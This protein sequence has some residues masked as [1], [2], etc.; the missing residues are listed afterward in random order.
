MTANDQITHVMMPLNS[1]SAT[2]GGIG[3]GNSSVRSFV[4]RIERVADVSRPWWAKN[5]LVS[6]IHSPWPY[7]VLWLSF[8]FSTWAWRKRLLSEPESNRRRVSIALL[9]LPTKISHWDLGIL[10]IVAGI[11]LIARFPMLALGLVAIGVLAKLGENK[12]GE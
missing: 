11:G 9:L 5:W 8:C 2:P 12:K 1:S 4:S 10:A 7:I 6:S 3:G